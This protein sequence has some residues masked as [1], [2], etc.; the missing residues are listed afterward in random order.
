MRGS[1]K[2]TVARA[3]LRRQFEALPVFRRVMSCF[4]GARLV[5]VKLAEKNTATEED[6]IGFIL[7]QHDHPDTGQGPRA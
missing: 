3:R 5:E 1:S 7:Q 4:E 2:S 6:S